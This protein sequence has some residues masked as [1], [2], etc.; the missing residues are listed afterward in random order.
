MRFS[1]GVVTAASK[2]YAKALVVNEPNI[3]EL[4]P[5]IRR[6]RIISSAD[7]VALAEPILVATTGAYFERNQT[8]PELRKQIRS[9]TEIDPIK[10]LAEAAR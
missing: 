1:T 7:I 9:G 8:V 4:Y 5:M 2:A 6:M 10:D 3:S